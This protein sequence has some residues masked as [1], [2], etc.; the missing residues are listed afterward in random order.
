MKKLFENKFFIILFLFLIFGAVTV[1]GS[2]IG[3]SGFSGIQVDHYYSGE[4]NEGITQNISFVDGDAFTHTFQIEDGLVVDYSSYPIF[5]IEGLLSYYKL[6]EIS[7][8]IT[9]SLKINNGTNYYATLYAA[10]KMENASKLEGSSRSNGSYIAF[11]NFVRPSNFTISAWVN[12]E[13]FANGDPY[14]GAT[15]IGGDD[16]NAGNLQRSFSLTDR[17]N[18]G[19]ILVYIFVG[20]SRYELDSGS[21]KLETSKW[22]YLATTYDGE[23]LK[24]YINGTLIS[25]NSS[26]SGSIDFGTGI[27][28]GAPS[29]EKHVDWFFDG[30]LD[31]IGIWNRSLSSD[32]ISI[33]Y[34]NGDGLSY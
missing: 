4:G 21:I 34:N 15:F 16:V 6:N 24:L 22:Y 7:G 1:I 26:M 28:F 17:N 11:S 3:E 23:D 30:V 31:E 14:G 8:I 33:L 20:G 32:E 12:A 2:S 25:T 29:D 13:S 5:P 18:G 19:E 27:A 9:D 10:G